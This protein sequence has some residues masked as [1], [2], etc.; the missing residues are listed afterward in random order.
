MEC[1]ILT[2]EAAL[3]ALAPEWESLQERC[4]KSIFTA[5]HW[6]GS[7]WRHLGREA[8][9]TLHIAVGRRD[10]RLVAVAPMAV[11]LRKGLRMLEWAAADVADYCD[12]LLEDGGGGTVI[13]DAIRKSRHYDLA[14]LK[15][16]HPEALCL[17]Q[18]EGFAQQVR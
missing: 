10:G 5:Y 3:A 15:D 7:W 13:W 1:E 8:G 17:A 16:I 9:Y 18:L 14:R 11:A 6:C 12:F 2:T 4:G